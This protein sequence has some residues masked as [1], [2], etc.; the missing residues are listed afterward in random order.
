VRAENPR[1][2]RRTRI[3]IRKRIRRIRI[4]IRI[5]IRRIRIRIR[6]TRRTRRTSTKMSIPTVLARPRTPPIIQSLT[7]ITRL[8]GAQLPVVH[9]SAAM[10]RPR[11]PLQGTCRHRVLQNTITAGLP[12]GVYQ[13]HQ[14]QGSTGLGP[15]Q[16]NIILGMLP[17]TPLHQA[18]SM[19]GLLQP[20]HT[21]TGVHHSTGVHHH[22]ST[23]VHHHLLTS[24]TSTEAHHRHT[25]TEAHRMVTN[26]RVHHNHTST[27]VRHNHSSMGVRH[28][29]SST[30]VR[31]NHISTGVRHNHTN[32]GVH[33]NLSS[34]EHLEDMVTAAVDGRRR[35]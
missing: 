4:R 14:R 23:G 32:T 10:K 8:S 3:R 2:R 19:E 16:L 24:T 13:C 18:V 35:A 9:R 27:G 12:L 28:N 21:I 26:T 5:R 1:R 11:T 33:H 6:R 25:S 30:A 22:T 34:R 29:H 20:L 15:L 31:H 17:P 7:A